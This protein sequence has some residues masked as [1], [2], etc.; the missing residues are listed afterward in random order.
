MIA[1]RAGAFSCLQT[2]SYTSC[3]IHTLNLLFFYTTSY[4]PRTLMVAGLAHL[5]SPVWFNPKLFTFHTVCFSDISSY[6]LTHHLFDFM[7]VFTD[8]LPTHR[9]HPAVHVL[10]VRGPSGRGLLVLHNSLH[11]GEPNPCCDRRMVI[12]KYCSQSVPPQ[13][14]VLNTRPRPPII[15]SYQTSVL[16]AQVV[17]L[18]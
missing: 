11:R 12:T 18:T 7:S 14:C 1:A 2:Y 13:L 15:S 10:R 8:V 3:I 6:F 17:E 5:P 4:T 16:S 9:E